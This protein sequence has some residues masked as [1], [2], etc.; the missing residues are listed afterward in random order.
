MKRRLMF[1]DGAVSVEHVRYFHNGPPYFKRSGRWLAMSEWAVP[2]PEMLADFRGESGESEIESD[3][4]GQSD[5]LMKPD[6]A[7]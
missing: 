1:S 7:G 6:G 4:S 3:Q 2:T 5:Q